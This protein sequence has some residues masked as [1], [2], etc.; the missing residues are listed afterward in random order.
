M[1]SM[2]SLLSCNSGD[3]SMLP[4]D[5]GNLADFDDPGSASNSFAE[6]TSQMGSFIGRYCPLVIRVMVS[7]LLFTIVCLY[8]GMNNDSENGGEKVTG[9]L[10]EHEASDAPVWQPMYIGNIHICIYRY[11]GNSHRWSP[12]TAEKHSLT[13]QQ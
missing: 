2:A 10:S 3:N 4:T 11:I 8:S 13:S 1:I 7:F 12:S 9:S 6:F 5:V